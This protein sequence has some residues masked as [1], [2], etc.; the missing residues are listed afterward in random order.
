M[1]CGIIVSALTTK[2][3]DLTVLVT[4]GIQLLMYGSAII[5]P[6][7]ALPDNWINIIM[8]NPIVPIVETFRY[9]LTGKGTF[10]P[11]YLLLSIVI[12]MIILFV[13]VVIFNKVEKTFMDTV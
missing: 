2:Y 11:E 8:L 4:F 1:G 5:F 7:S 6:V 9:G 10:L 13:G 3:R 12:T